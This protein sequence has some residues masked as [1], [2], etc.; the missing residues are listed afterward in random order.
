MRNLVTALLT[1]GALLGAAGSASAVTAS[2]TFT[3]SV[4]VNKTCS[5]AATSLGF[6][7]YTPGV[8]SV[9]AI[10]TVS[11]NCTKGTTYTVGL[12]KGTTAGGTVAQR[13]MVQS[14]GTSTLQYNLCT[15]AAVPATG[16]CNGATLWGDGTTG[17][18]TQSGT[19]TGMGVGNVQSL[20]VYGGLPDNAVNQA[21]AV[22]G[23]SNG[24]SDVVTVNV[25]Y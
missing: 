14:G 18:I 3:V 2:N 1:T 12:D 20:T 4:T 23:V 19:G 5:V 10:S 17:T 15:T 11:V 21:A 22:N 8:A 9:T 16:L 7:N 6:G 25:N 13:L 24:Y